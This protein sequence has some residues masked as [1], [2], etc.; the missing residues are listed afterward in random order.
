MQKRI[1]KAVI[2]AAGLGTRFLPATKNTPK[3]LLPI[4]DRPTILY[5]V[6]EAI[7]AGVE[8]I[9]FISGR[10]KHSI[11]DFFDRNVELETH[12]ES[13]NQTE[14]LERIQDISN[15]ANIISVR[16]KKALGLGHAVGCAQVAVGD[17]PFAV[18]LGD[19]ITV[20][21]DDN[22][23]NALQTLIEN[24]NDKNESVTSI[25][26]VPKED[27]SKYGI[28]D[29]D[30]E[31][32]TLLK[33]KNVI[34]KPT[35]DEAP[36]QFALP[37]RYVFKPSIFEYI[38]SAKPGRNGEIQLTDAM[39]LEAKSNGLWGAQVDALR[40]DAGDKLGYIIANI[41]MAL[42]NKELS[43]PLKN[44]LKNKLPSL[45]GEL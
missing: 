28:V 43:E 11:E 23:N 1:K 13:K 20:A 44:Y 10:G 4:V 14:L 38:K 33:I 19:E 42:K 37:G 21:K 41:E 26:K 5:V 17:E 7:K 30:S 6:E 15:M 35:T 40:Y 25:M 39:T 2:P 29:V 22:S 16:Q 34:E 8:D 45:T 31:E 24:F 27:V 3:E 12:L 36:S 18:L 32:G 9:I